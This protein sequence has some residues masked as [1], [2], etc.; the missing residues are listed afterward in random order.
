M[1]K[2]MLNMLKKNIG[3]YQ[4]K[5]DLELRVQPRANKIRTSSKQI[6]ALLRRNNIKQAKELFVEITCDWRSINKA[7]NDSHDLLNLSCY[8]EAAEEYVEALAY[9]SFLASVDLSIPEF[10]RVDTEEVISGICDFTG[11]LVRRAIT[12]ASAENIDKI[13]TDKKITEDIVEELTKIRLGKK[14]RSKYDDAERNLKK[15]ENVIYDIKMKMIRNR[16]EG[17]AGE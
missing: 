16:S 10:V 6:T 9:W 4:K 12:E 3:K 14:M 11:E 5:Q 1:A 17:G 8:K 7:A 13:N 15:L 2:N